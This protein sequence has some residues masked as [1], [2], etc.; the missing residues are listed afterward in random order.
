VTT[1]RLIR[2]IDTNAVSR[3][4]FAGSVAFSP[5][6]RRV[7]AGLLDGKA[8]LWDIA[9][10]QHLQTLEHGDARGA[11]SALAF[12]PDGATVL[13]VGQNPKAKLWDAA[14]GKL[15][16]TF[17]SSIA[18]IGNLHG[19]AVAFSPDGA[20]VAVATANVVELWNAATGE[21]IR[22]LYAVS[23]VRHI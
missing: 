17:A 21:L 2:T 16:R 23:R 6:G 18:N 8:A 4:G 1:G 22:A 11:V 20:R 5:D 3:S 13:T 19:D 14:T 10:G 15:A 7:A 12:S 9:T